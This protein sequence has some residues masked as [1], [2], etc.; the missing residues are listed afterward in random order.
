VRALKSLDPVR[1]RASLGRLHRARPCDAG[2][3]GRCITIFI[4]MECCMGIDRLNR[5]VNVVSRSD[6][7]RS[8]FQPFLRYR[9]SHMA[10]PVL[11]YEDLGLIQGAGWLFRHIDLHLQPNA[12]AWR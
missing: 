1:E 11:A 12:I 10:A 8:R 4:S 2:N 9:Y 7:F 5:R 3:T 6:L